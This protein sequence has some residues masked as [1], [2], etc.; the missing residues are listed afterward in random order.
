M[1]RIT[2][3]QASAASTGPSVVSKGIDLAERLQQGDAYLEQSRTL[4]IPPETAETAE[5][6]RAHGTS[7]ITA[8]TQ[9]IVPFLQ[10]IESLLAEGLSSDLYELEPRMVEHTRAFFRLV[11]TSI[12]DQLGLSEPPAIPP[13]ID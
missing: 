11:H 9:E 8:R 7:D 3:K 5:Y 4:L 2:G 13:D 10:R 12:A 6:M 1:N